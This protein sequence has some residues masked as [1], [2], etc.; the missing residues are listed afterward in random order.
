M[1]RPMLHRS[2]LG[3]RLLGFLVLLAVSG[4]AL[5][6]VAQ[7]ESSSASDLAA[8]RY[9][10]AGASYKGAISTPTRSDDVEGPATTSSL[11]IPPE[12]DLVPAPHIEFSGPYRSIAARNVFGLRALVKRANPEASTASASK[13]DLILTGACSIG[14]VR[15][16]IFKL[17][18]PAKPVVFFTLKEGEQNDWLE[19]LSIDAPSSRVNVRLKQ[20]VMR[21]Q[22]AGIDAIITFESNPVHKPLLDMQNADARGSSSTR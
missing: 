19:V 14:D 22:K 21:M 9:E 16:A 5:T 3:N 7:D 2:K 13:P 18:E 1:A 4:G 12:P 8:H 15:Y 11:I 10:A 6:A 20:P 17:V